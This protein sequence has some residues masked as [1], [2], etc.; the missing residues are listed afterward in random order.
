M[1]MTEPLATFELPRAADAPASPAALLFLRGRDADARIQ[2]LVAARA[3]VRPLLASLTLALVE[4]R[5]FEPL[6]FRSL[7][8]YGRERLGLTAR[9]LREWAR[10]WRALEG[11]PLLRAALVAGE[12]SWSVA[13][14]IVAFVT[15]ETEAASLESVRGRTVRAVEAMLATVFPDQPTAASEPG[16]HVHV[17]VH[18]PAGT[19]ARWQ[20]ALELAR[21]MAGEALPV[22]ECAE[23]IAAEAL[24]GI[25]A[26]SVRRAADL[27]A[28]NVVRAPGAAPGRRAGSATREHGLRHRAFPH[29][30]WDARAFKALRDP[31]ALLVSARALSPHALDAALRRTLRRLQQLDHDLGRLLRQVLDRRLHLELGFPSFE[32][33][34][35]ERSDVSP[36]T[37]RRWVRLARLGPEKS[38]LANAF[39]AGQVT[40]AQALVVAAASAPGTEA[41]W[42]AFARAH[43]LRRLEDEAA[44]AGD[45]EIVSFH[46]P[47]EAAS[48]FL[49]ALEAARLHLG[50]ER[51][52]AVSP[53]EAL[54]WILEHATASFTEQGA[55]FRDYADFT[56]DGFRCSVPGCTARRNLHAHHVK[57]RSAGGPDEA[58]NRT[59]LCAFHHLRGV[60]AHTVRCTGR[61]PGDLL[62]ELGVRA[63]ATALVVA[64][65]GDVLAGC[66]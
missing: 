30:R 63:S 59:T 45:G 33:Y 10:V 32:R 18:G 56:R 13:R 37:A 27:T 3:G 1:A 60:H 53:G 17:R 40:E 46:A 28:P 66:L 26:G 19:G 9:A 20:A 15:P 4:R 35:E 61:A 5:A 12:L 55:Q 14:R 22:W 16:D 43:T 23:A 58:W 6:G 41:H 62:F 64:R 7:G 31:Q 11:L 54:I 34:V 24:G 49:L 50:E 57:F 47:R 39:R 2:A 52:Q 42:L 38:A 51:A 29:L 25:P 21:R 36:R 44:A 65:S 48:V 8:D